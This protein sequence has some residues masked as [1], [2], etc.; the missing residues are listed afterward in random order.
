[1]SKLLS[2]LATE[3]GPRDSRIYFTADFETAESYAAYKHRRAGNARYYPVI[4]RMSID[5]DV[6]MRRFPGS[7][8]DIPY[9]ST[10]WM[11]LAWFSMTSPRI[12]DILHKYT[13]GSTLLKMAMP[14]ETAQ[15]FVCMRSWKDNTEDHVMRVPGG[16]DAVMQYV[17]S[18]TDDDLELLQEH[19]HFDAYSDPTNM[20]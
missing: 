11:Q 14:R 10:E 20:L 8:H 5:K 3:F 19:A 12:P 9:P 7:Q 4:A 1:M 13:T 2:L 15:V 16:Q 18:G 6:L 17:F